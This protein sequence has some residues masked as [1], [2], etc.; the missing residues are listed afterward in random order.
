MSDSNYV[1]GID[2]ARLSSVSTAKA[3]VTRQVLSNFPAGYNTYSPAYSR[4]CNRPAKTVQSVSRLSSK[5]K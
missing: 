2:L 1:Y 5:G 4:V 3:V